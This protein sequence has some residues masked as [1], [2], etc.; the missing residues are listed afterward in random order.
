[1]WERAVGVAPSD[2]CRQRNL[3]LR[4]TGAGLVLLGT[5]AE[6][7]LRG[8]GQPVSRGARAWTWCVAGH[9][10]SGTVTGVFARDGRLG[11]VAST[12]E[13]H[14]IGHVGSGRPASA[15]PASARQVAPGLFVRQA[16]RHSRFVYGTR[17]GRVSFVAV[18]ANALTGSAKALQATLRAGRI[19]R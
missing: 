3:G 9:K 18:G 17:G 5:P 10:P 6:D 2:R 15:V 19:R 11:L 8:A 7:V 14:R 16:G 4:P 12:A 1:M 13:H